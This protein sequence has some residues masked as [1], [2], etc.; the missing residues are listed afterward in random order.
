MLGPG[1]GGAW[2]TTGAGGLGVEGALGAGDEGTSAAGNMGEA[3]VMDLVV[4][5]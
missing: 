1:D 5:V 4:L 2:Y 3:L